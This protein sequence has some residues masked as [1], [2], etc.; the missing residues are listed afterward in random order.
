MILAPVIIGLLIWLI[1]WLISKF[2]S[3]IADFGKNQ[4][5]YPPLSGRTAADRRSARLVHPPDYLCPN[6]YRTYCLSTRKR[7]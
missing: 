2:T 6:C 4:A 7:E 5:F 3:L 1:I